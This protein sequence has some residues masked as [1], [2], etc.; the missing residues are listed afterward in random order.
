MWGEALGFGVSAGTLTLG[1][2]LTPH[3]TRYVMG[4]GAVVLYWWSGR[5]ASRELGQAN[6]ALLQGRLDEIRARYNV[7]TLWSFAHPAIF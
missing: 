2:V 7:D 4:S 6:A 3:W 5:A 1:A